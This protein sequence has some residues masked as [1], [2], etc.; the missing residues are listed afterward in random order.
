MVTGIGMGDGRMEGDR[1]KKHTSSDTEK[2]CDINECVGPHQYLENE[3]D[4]GSAVNSKRYNER[5]EELTETKEAMAQR[6]VTNPVLMVKM[7]FGERHR[8]ERGYQECRRPRTAYQS[9]NDRVGSI[10]ER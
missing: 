8:D 2:E 5:M 10:T 7:I 1:R 3:K 4:G 9:A 6:V